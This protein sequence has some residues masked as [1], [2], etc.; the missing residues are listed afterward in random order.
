MKEKLKSMG[1]IYETNWRLRGIYGAD[2]SLAEIPISGYMQNEMAT[3]CSQ[4][5]PPVEEVGNQ[6]NHKTFN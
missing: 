4:T 2:P 5:G 1:D 6:S 3:S